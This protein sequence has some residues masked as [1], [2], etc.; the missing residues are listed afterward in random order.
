MNSLELE[1]F[2]TNFL[3]IYRAAEQRHNETVAAEKELEE[4][5]QD[6]LHYCEFCTEEALSNPTQVIS[7]LA[8]IRQKRRVAKKEL[9]VATTFWEWANNNRSTMGKL[10][11]C[12][13]NIRKTIVRQPQAAYRFKTDYVKTKND[14]ITNTN[15]KEKEN[16]ENSADQGN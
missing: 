7:L 4:A 10:N 9:E 3:S 2:L 8:E 14:W 12:L 6:L 16:N 1:E 5:Q 15:I 11:D 13:G